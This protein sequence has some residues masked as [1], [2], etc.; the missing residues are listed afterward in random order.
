MS[1]GVKRRSDLALPPVYRST[2]PAPL[3]IDFH[4]FGPPSIEEGFSGLTV[5]AAGRHESP[6][7]QAGMVVLTP[8]GTAAGTTPAWNVTHYAPWPNDEQFAIDLL[9]YIEAHACI[10]TARVYLTGFAIGAQMAAVVACDHADR[11]TALAAVSG[12]YDPAGCQPSRALP[13][14][15]FNGTADPMIPYAGGIGPNVPKLG[16][17]AATTAGETAMISRLAPI[18]EVVNRWVRRDG[19]QPAPHTTVPAKSVTLKRWNRCRGGADIDWYLISGAGHT[20]PSSPGTKALGTLLGPTSDAI[21]ATD[22]IIQFFDR[23]RLP[24]HS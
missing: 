14:I 17:D 9:D 8:L 10:D 3:I 13:I 20:W 24:P 23:Y 12:I 22:L 16:L 19:C 18:P 6:A 2:T 7:G 11:I 21:P 15:A 4:P 5:I 1:S